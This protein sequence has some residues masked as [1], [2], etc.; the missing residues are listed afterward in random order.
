MV[1]RISSKGQ[2]TIPTRVRDAIGLKAGDF[3]SYEV[4]ENAVLLKRIEPVDLEFHR[5]L[6]ATLEEWDSPQD[7]EAFRDL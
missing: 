3:V 1:S 4:H 6:C 5:A 7:E 2:I